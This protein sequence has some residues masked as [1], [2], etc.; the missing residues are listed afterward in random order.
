VPLTDCEIHKT[1]LILCYCNGKTTHIASN[2]VPHLGCPTEHC[3]LSWSGYERV[4]AWLTEH[5]AGWIIEPFPRI[6]DPSPK[7]SA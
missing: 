2:T 1:P 7:D 4:A 6:T 3:T 5:E